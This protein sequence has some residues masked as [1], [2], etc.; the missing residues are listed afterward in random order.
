MEGITTATY[1]GSPLVGYFAVRNSIKNS[2]AFFNLNDGGKTLKV[3][4]YNCGSFFVPGDTREYLCTV[5]TDMANKLTSST[6]FDRETM[7]C[8]CCGSF[9]KKNG[10]PSKKTVR[11]VLILTDHAFPAAL[12]AG[13]GGG[14]CVKI[15]RCESSSLLTI[16]ETFLSLTAGWSLAGGSV[17]LLNSVSHLAR[18]G[19]SAYVTDFFA[20]AQKIKQLTGADVRP[21]PF[22]LMGGTNDPVLIRS[23]VD[24]ASWQKLYHC[25]D[26]LFPNAAI[27][28]SVRALA[29]LGLGS[30]QPR[31]EC[32]YELPLSIRSNQSVVWV[33]DDLSRLPYGSENISVELEQKIVCELINFLNSAL[34]IDLDPAPIQ[35]R[36]VEPPRSGGNKMCFVVVGNSHAS[37]TAAAM[38]EDGLDVVDVIIPAC[39][40]SAANVEVI[41]ARICKETSS[42]QPNK[43]FCIVF[44]LFDNA[45]YFSRGEDGSLTPAT[46]SSGCFHVQGDS[47][48]APKELQFHAFKQ[49]LPALNVAA[50][51]AEATI[52][53]PP[54]PRYWTRGCCQDKRHVANLKEDSYQ[55]E[56][57]T[58]VYN[59]KTNL[60]DFAFTARLKN[61]KVIAAWAAIKKLPDIWAT[62]PVHLSPSGY[63]TIGKVVA[64]CAP[65]L[66]SKRE[67]VAAAAASSSSGYKKPRVGTP[68]AKPAYRGSR[69]SWYRG[70]KHGRY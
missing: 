36:L 49:L 59:S 21:A 20:A 3:D 41:R 28:S 56:L 19:V 33:S 29:E 65:A 62:D 9:M 22:I 18:V 38:R 7:A 57:E 51:A 66:P 44:Q 54:L 48:I 13:G 43:K 64:A 14:N 12:P 47:V 31:V 15:V 23:L 53:I 52:L 17:I 35:N 8:A 26:D 27:C 61:C 60:R 70:H 46:K 55:S 6:S 69:G 58:S 4:S 5:K 39:R 40:I 68:P 30:C 1:S 25:G 42:I 24:L 16:S 10:D 63:S 34:A 2:N 32:R 45:F 11:A 50:A 37:R 67:H